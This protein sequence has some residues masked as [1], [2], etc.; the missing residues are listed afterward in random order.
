MISK[1]KAQP[2]QTVCMERVRRKSAGLA[3]ARLACAAIPDANPRTPKIRG[4][5]IRRPQVGDTVF[6]WDITWQKRTFDEGTV[7]E[8]PALGTNSK[9]FN[10][11]FKDKN[12]FDIPFKTTR[13]TH[14][15]LNSD[16]VVPQTCLKLLDSRIAKLKKA[17]QK[18]KKRKHPEATKN[19]TAV[20]HKV[21][22]AKLVASNAASQVQPQTRGGEVEN[23]KEM[24]KRQPSSYTSVDSEHRRK[25]VRPIRV[26]WLCT[27]CK[28]NCACFD[29][30]H[31]K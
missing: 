16:D 2:G 6:V 26:A 10:V 12:V 13:K 19:A 24:G 23:E 8:S 29:I 14:W 27:Q 5:P 15:T 22:K 17:I 28:R 18:G 31:G 1:I 4:L 30:Y 11:H 25:Q 3:A 20:T 9:K 7:H 21:S